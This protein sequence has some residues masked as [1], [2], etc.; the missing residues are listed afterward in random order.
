MHDCTKESKKFWCI[1]TLTSYCYSMFADITEYGWSTVA[2][3]NRVPWIAMISPKV[4]RDFWRRK[5]FLPLKNVATN[6]EDISTCLAGGHS[7]H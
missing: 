6:T 3:L 4:A 1:V 7:S 5:L 2:F